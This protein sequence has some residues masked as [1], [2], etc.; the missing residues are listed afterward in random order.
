[1]PIATTALIEAPTPVPPTEQAEP[2][3]FFGYC[4]TCDREINLAEMKR[5]DETIEYFGIG[6]KHACP[7]CHQLL[8][9][10]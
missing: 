4:L 6:E 3:P 9:P 2:S 10:F 8:I 5:I 1:M 7:T